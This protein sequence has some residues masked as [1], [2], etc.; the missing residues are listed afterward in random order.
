MLLEAGQP[1]PARAAFEQSL[2]TEPNRFRS[3]FG[4]ARGAELAG[5]TE[6]ARQR[7]GDLLRIAATADTDRPEL[8]T[9]RGFL[10][11]H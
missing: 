6:G 9:A 4:A 8:Q 7:Y 10:A 5:D 11:A 3:A 1:G 2:T